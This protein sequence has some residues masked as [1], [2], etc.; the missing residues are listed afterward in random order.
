MTSVLVFDVGGTKVR[1]AIYDVDTDELG[2]VLRRPAP[3]FLLWPDLTPR[4]LCERFYD[5][6]THCAEQLQAANPTH[7][8]VAFPGPVSPRGVALHAP[9]LWGASSSNEP[10]LQRL[11]QVWPQARI[12]VVNDLTAAGYCFLR[13]DDEDFC[14]ITVSSGIGHKVFIGGAPALGPEGRGGEIGHWRIDM[15]PD[16]PR[17]DCGGQGHLGAVASGRAS[18]WQAEQLATKDQVAFL[19]SSLGRTLKGDLNGLTNEQLVACFHEGDAW[20]G[21]LVRQM[22]IPLARAIAAIHVAVGTGRFVITGG[23]AHALGA[24]YV[25]LLQKLARQYCWCPGNGP[26]FNVEPGQMSGDAC[27]V[28]AGRLAKKKLMASGEQNE[29]W[30]L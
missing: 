20:T 26:A 15:D 4:A 6:L 14:V 24:P 30:T 10:V 16:A 8:A 27:L 28:G 11:R 17:C 7:V 22:A 12:I 1:A 2:P 25:E 29:G 3:N 18:R 9:T 13:R 19:D 5:E 23:F 21:D